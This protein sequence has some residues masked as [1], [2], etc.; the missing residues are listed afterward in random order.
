[1]EIE[2]ITT[3]AIQ[4][5]LD[6]VKSFGILLNKTSS[7]IKMLHWFVMDHNTHEILGELYDDLTDLFDK[8]EEEIIGTCKGENVLFPMCSVDV[9]SQMWD[10]VETYS[11]NASIIS[12]FF[13][14]SK[15]MK[16]LLTSLEFTNYIANVKSGINNTKEDIISR[17]NKAEYLISMVK[18]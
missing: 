2:I 17:F 6:T 11:D 3:S 1:M 16:D 12:H 5:K 13:V 10:L 7:T 14:I 8:L 9:F 18:I 15:A 4:D